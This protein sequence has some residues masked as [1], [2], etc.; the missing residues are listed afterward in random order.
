MYLVCGLGK[1]MLLKRVFMIKMFGKK[2]SQIGKVV[3]N[4]LMQTGFKISKKKKC[5]MDII[6]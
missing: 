5:V 2:K 6:V 3:I 4:F 1:N